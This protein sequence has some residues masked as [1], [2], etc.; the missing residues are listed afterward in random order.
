MKILKLLC[1][2]S[3]FSAVSVQA[4]VFT[5]SSGGLAASATFSVNEATDTLTVTLANTSSADVLVPADVLTAVFFNVSGNP[6]LTST[7]ALL[8]AGSVVVNDT[9]TTVVGG[10]WAYSNGLNQFGANSGISS[11]GFGIFGNP[12]FTGPDLD[13]PLAVNGINY[14]ILSAGDNIATG[15]SA[16]LSEPFVKNQVVFT[17]TG[18][19]LTEAAISNVT[20]QY[21]TSLNGTPGG[22]PSFPGETPTPSVPDAGSSVILL[23]VSTL[24]LGL[25]RRRFVHRSA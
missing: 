16:V 20:F 19:T 8:P 13:D 22:E 2:L 11:S 21:G 18:F 15:N 5:G 4:I 1:L 3:G 14:G 24:L 23:G 17:L 7:T 10:E 25:L 9:P 12:T 6:L